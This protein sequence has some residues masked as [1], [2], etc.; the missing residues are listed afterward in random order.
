MAHSTAGLTAA[1]TAPQRS[2]LAIS[3]APSERP[4]A[5]AHPNRNRSADAH[6]APFAGMT[7]ACRY[8]Y[9]GRSPCRAPSFP[10]TSSLP[11]NTDSMWEALRTISRGCD[12]RCI[13]RNESQ[14]PFTMNAVHEQKWPH[15]LF[16]LRT[17]FVKGLFTRRR[18]GAEISRVSFPASAAMCRFVATAS[19]TDPRRHK[20]I[21]KVGPGSRPS[22]RRQNC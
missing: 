1:T 7:L 16:M 18:G 13:F 10:D 3:P 6:P 4:L 12:N 14:L 11:N 17:E 5:I 21:F 19:R 15:D 8:F 9:T 22:A 2:P 20:A